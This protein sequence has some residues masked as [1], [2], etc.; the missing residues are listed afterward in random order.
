MASYSQAVNTDVNGVKVVSRYDST[1][2]AWVTDTKAVDST[3]AVKSA[4]VC[5]AKTVSS[6][7]AEIFA[8]AS[9]LASRYTMSVYNDSNNTIYWGPSG[10]TTATGFPILP[11]DSL[12][13]QF[14]PVAATAIYMI[15]SASSAVRVV[16][17]A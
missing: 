6:S 13:L 9:R 4:P 3:F 8:G 2:S 12:T 14:S 15:A 7:A 10:V 16:E 11:G 5:G 17:L 1:L